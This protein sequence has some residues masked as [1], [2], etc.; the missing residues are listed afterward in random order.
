MN[1]EEHKALAFNLQ[2]RTSEAEVKKHDTGDSETAKTSLLQ[3]SFLEEV[4]LVASERT[5]TEAKTP[6]KDELKE[7]LSRL[8][9]NNPNVLSSNDWDSINEVFLSAL[10]KGDLTWNDENGGLEQRIKFKKKL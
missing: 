8:A 7:W 4:E 2:I 5:N 9:D 10:D 1:E 6:Q 3:N